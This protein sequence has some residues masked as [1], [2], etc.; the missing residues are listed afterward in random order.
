MP[1]STTVSKA[2]ADE[3]RIEL[4]AD[5]ALALTARMF[6]AAAA[7]HFGLDEAPIEDLRL[8]TSELFTNAVESG[9]GS[10]SFGLGRA[11]ERLVIHASGIGRLDSDDPV[12][13]EAG[14]IRSMATRRDLL[15][16][17]FPGIRVTF[18]DGGSVAIVTTIHV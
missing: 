9:N 6:V 17:L 15:E 14:G 1:E 5:A 2:V 18:D 4:P 10:V 7:R 13:V 12:A 11:G 16:A 8:A 3:V